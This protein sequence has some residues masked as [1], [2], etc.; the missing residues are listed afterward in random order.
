MNG[1]WVL[2]AAIL[3]SAMSFVDSTAVNVA[4]PVIQRDLHAGAVPLQWVVE[5]YTLFLSALILLGGALGDRYGRRR[6]FMIGIA[7]FALASLG[8]ALAPTIEIVDVARAVQGI[9]GALAVPES[10]ALLSASFTGE[11]RGQAIGTWSGFASITSAIGPLLGGFLAQH[12]SWRW[13]F[14]INLPLAVAVLL[15]CWRAVPESSDPEAPRR[16]DVAGALLATG[17][18]GALTVALIR[19]QS[20]PFDPSLW[21][22]FAAAATALAAF[23]VVERRQPAPMIPLQVFRSPAFS[24]ANLYTLFLYMALGGSLYFIPYLLINAQGYQPTA[25]GAALLPFIILNFSLARW[26]GGL[27]ARIGARTPLIV[28]AL[29]VAVA[30]VA[31]AR[32]G[33][34]GSYWTTY[35]PAVVM[36]GLGA[37]CFIAPLTTTVFDAAPSDASG[38]ASGINNAVART[39]GLLAVAAFGIVLVRVAPGAAQLGLGSPQA[40]LTGFR[41]VMECSAA[42]CLLA[43]LTAALTIPGRPGAAAV[44]RSGGLTAR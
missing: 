34:G 39:A 29:L 8:C 43:A 15:I 7:V 40:Y 17:G 31:F 38:V 20:G 18:L 26:S 14:L 1:R 37:A 35:F 27:V 12:A 5:G 19:A 33:L 9:G 4:L 32:P 44:G 21:W 28:G 36:L 41:A 22:L 10:L 13:V 23:V 25:A 3:G 42:V 30:F 11:A 24:G 6:L 2:I 16:P